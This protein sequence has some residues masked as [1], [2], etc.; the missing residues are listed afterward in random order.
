MNVTEEPARPAIDAALREL[1]RSAAFSGA[2]QPRKLFAY[3]VRN[4]LENNASCLNEL[5]V[6]ENVLGRRGD[7]VPLLDS[8]VRKAMSRLRAKLRDYYAQEGSGAAVR[9]VLEKYRVRFA[10]AT[11]P[12]PVL[13]LPISFTDGLT[14][15][16]KPYRAMPPMACRHTRS[17]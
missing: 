13:V 7:F 10:S 15:A 12:P 3:L 11:T 17:Q 2:E 6:A 9:F 5:A 4:S 8:S 14:A 1:L 16:R